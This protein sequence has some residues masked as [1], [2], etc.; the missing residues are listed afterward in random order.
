MSSFFELIRK[1]HD[2]YYLDN[3]PMLA[4]ALAYYSFFSIFPFLLFLIYFGSEV[5]AVSGLQQE[6]I[7]SLGQF[8]PTGAEAIAGVVTTTI[9]HSR[10]LGWVGLVGLLWSASSIFAVLETALNRIWRTRA[11]GFWRKRLMATLSILSLCLLFL[12]V[13]GL[14]HFLPSMLTLAEHPGT[15][16]LGQLTA[17]VLLIVVISLLYTILPNR[18]IPPR[19]AWL[20]GL[21]AATLLFTARA[22]FDLFIRSAFNNYGAVYGSLAWVVSLAL[23][24]Y[25]VAN[26]FLL[27]AELGSVLEKS[28]EKPV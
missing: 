4:A 2:K 14:G 27:G 21:T 16:W 8:L 13:I 28:E 24:A 5:L 19:I 17:F 25:V 12:V 18:R 1:T 23:W 9:S 15:Q 22:L 20:A 3:C 10:S 7:H 6:L 26:L 11:R